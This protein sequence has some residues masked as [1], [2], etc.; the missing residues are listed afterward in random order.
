MDA[1]LG[2][3]PRGGLRGTEDER[4]DDGDDAELGFKIEKKATFT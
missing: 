1:P 2:R 4:L 3:T